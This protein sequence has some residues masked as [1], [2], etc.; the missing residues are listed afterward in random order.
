MLQISAIPAFNDNYHW[1]ITDDL[2]PGKAYVVDPGDGEAVKEQLI[3]RQLTLLGI[4]I[5]HRHWDHVDGIPTL[6][7]YHNSRTSLPVYGPKADTIPAV[8]H[9]VYEQDCVRLFDQYPFTVM[10]TPGHTV[11]HIV[12]YHESNTTPILFCGDTLFGAGC[13]RRN[14]GTV[15]QFINSLERIANL[16]ENTQVYCAHEYTLDNLRF[17]QAVEPANP[18]INQRIAIETSKRHQ[19]I[20]TIPF[21]LGGEKQTNPF[22]RIHKQTIIES[23]KQYWGTIANTRDNIF[24]GLR[25][26]KDV[27]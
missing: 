26:W 18:D 9:P 8:T 4:L 25:R 24:D 15:K 5:T 27:F 17:A 12:Y 11:E 2:Y 19:R 6:L 20:P 7:H 13:G 22:L 21:S 23:V 10:E 3:A 1:L 16:P 14:D